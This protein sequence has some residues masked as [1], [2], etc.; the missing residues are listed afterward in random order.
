MSKRLLRPAVFGGACAL[1]LAGAPYAPAQTASAAAAGPAAATSRVDFYRNDAAHTGYTSS[2]ITTPLSVVWRH[3]TTQTKDSPASPIYAEGVVYFGAGGHVYAVNAADGT[4]KWQYP[5]GEAAATSFR[6][7]PALAGGY[8]YVG[9]DDSQLYKLDAGTGA[10]A[11]PKPFKAGGAIRS[12]PVVDGGVVYFGSSDNNL[13]AVSADTAQAVWLGATQGP[14]TAAP[15]IAAGQVVVASEDNSI[16]SFSTGG[17]RRSWSIRLSADPS[18]AAPV[19]SEST[20]FLGAGDTLYALNARTGSAR[21]TQRLSAEV[22]APPAVG[23]GNVYA[24]TQDARVYD[25]STRGRQLWTAQIDAPTNAAPLLAGGTLI[26]PT[27]HGVLYALDAA[28]GKRKWEYVVQATATQTQP[29]YTFTDI[30]S[31]PIFV[32]GALYVLSDD[33]SLTAFRADGV[34]AVPPQVTAVYPPPGAA[35]PGIHT[36]YAVQVFDDGTGI[37]PATVKL[38]VDGT[39][40]SGVKYDPSKNL[41]T[42]DEAAG[43]AATS[44]KDGPHLATLTAADWRGNALTHSWGFVV[45]NRLNRPGATVAVPASSSTPSDTASPTAPPPPGGATTARPRR[46]GRPAPPDSGTALPPPPPPL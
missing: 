8:L 42:L 32:D 33:G 40:L 12:S 35:A 20:L 44:L 38:S 6:T 1:A 23:A 10:A 2:P 16:Y 41:V 14:I 4:V 28:T 45:D 11:W 43:G 29:K 5:A 24:V 31:A 26:V 30:A 39:A 34:D 3:T 13:Y 37:D 18:A 36:L 25:F 7:T 46:G 19:F 21:W 27:Q 15:T 9:G 17:G 22:T